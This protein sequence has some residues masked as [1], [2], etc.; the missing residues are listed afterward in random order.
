MVEPL[1]LAHISDLHFGVE[2]DKA[3]IA[4]LQAILPTFGADAIVISGDLTQ[5]AR[6]NE[7]HAARSFVNALKE[8]TPVLVS[9]GNHDVTWW[10][11]PFHIGGRERIYRKYIEFFGP[12]LAPTLQLPRAI[13]VSC[14]TSH[15]LTVGSMTWNLRD[16]T[17]KGHLPSSELHRAQRRFSEVPESVVRVLVVH[18]NVLRGEIS[19]RMG[20]ARWRS[21]NVAINESGADL[22]LC[23]HDHQESA[24][25]ID[26]KVVVSTSGTHCAR[27]RGGRPSAFHL[28]T[29]DPNSISI[30]Q[31]RWDAPRGE[32]V[33]SHLHRFARWRVASL[34]GAISRSDPSS[35]GL[36]HAGRPSR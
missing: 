26:G 14:L 31:M 30:R 11:G 33:A 24:G 28:I 12:D 9:P 34:G 32:F 17:V 15:G 5:R 20:L 10:A 36:V 19:D 13:I 21:A 27:T 18:H 3:Q 16:L 7:F 6:R 35:E 29:V 1:I 8:S 25:Q 23:G 2:V 22:V 4:S